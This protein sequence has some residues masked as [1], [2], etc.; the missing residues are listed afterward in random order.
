MGKITKPLRDSW[1]R[2]LII[3]LCLILVAVRMIWPNMKVDVISLWLLGI[4]AFLL[5]MPR[6]RIFIPYIKRIKLGE[7]ELELSE[8]IKNF[9]KEVEKVQSSEI[10]NPQVNSLNN[11]SPD[12]MKVLEEAPKNPTAALL[13]LA[14]ML[15]AHIKQRFLES[16][17][18][19]TPQ[20]PLAALK[21]M[22]DAGIY[23]SA[24]LKSYQYFRDIR[25]KVAHGLAF[26]VSDSIL[27]SIISLGTELLKVLSTKI[28]PLSMLY[29]DQGQYEQAEPLL[30]RALAISEQQ[31]GP[32]HPNMASSLNNLAA[33]YQDQGKYE[34][35]EPLYLRAL[36]IYEQQLGPEHPWTAT[37]LNTL[38]T[39]YRTQG[40]YKQA[41]ALY[42]RALAIREQ[43]LGPDHPNTAQSVSWLAALSEQQQQYEQ[44]AS[45]YQRA[46]AIDEHALG[47][48]HPL[49]QTIRANYARLLRTM[50]HDAEATALD[51][52]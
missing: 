20:S 17:L 36:S 34:L 52:P 26:D 41:E 28:G 10:E 30:K 1:Q 2:A 24:V 45:L 47:P 16:R 35:A 25:N 43:Q 48:Q 38:A 39:L 6:L 18:R 12:V 22:V 31:L 49:T 8:E 9:G 44:A 19:N 51:P 42:L 11:I 37:S 3:L 7:T 29:Q 23:S 40:K 46:L 5:L 33:L 14:T 4:A 15:D 13:L 32:D 27:L 21:M 50:R